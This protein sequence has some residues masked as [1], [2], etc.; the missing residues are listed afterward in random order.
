LATSESS[1]NGTGRIDDLVSGILELE[2]QVPFDKVRWRS[3]KQQLAATPATDLADVAAKLTVVHHEIQVDVDQ[4]DSN[5]LQSAISEL[6]RVSN[7]E[8]E[9]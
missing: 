6:R 9:F 7:S 5:I 2:L 4:L 3:L 1:D 8:K